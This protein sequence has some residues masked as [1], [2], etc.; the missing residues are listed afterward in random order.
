MDE[1]WH[2]ILNRGP[3]NNKDLAWE[4]SWTCANWRVSDI[5]TGICIYV[6]IDGWQD[7]CL[8]HDPIWGGL[9]LP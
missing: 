7:G 2:L 8:G 3:N 4:L 9:I 1:R 5:N 6:Y